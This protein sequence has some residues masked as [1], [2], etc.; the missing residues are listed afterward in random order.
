MDNGPPFPS[1][2]GITTAN[3]AL[4]NLVNLMFCRYSEQ[5]KKLFRQEKMK[6]M[7]S[8]LKDI[9]LSFHCFVWRAKNLFFLDNI[10]VALCVI[11]VLTPS[12][13]VKT[14][15]INSDK[16]KNDVCFVILSNLFC[17]E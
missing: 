17:I 4:E 13:K 6:N 3:I 16:I 14:V 15:E 9:Y 12:L 11:R 8:N 7:Y 10:S 5:I 2:R 1:S